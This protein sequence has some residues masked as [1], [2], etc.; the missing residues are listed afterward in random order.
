MMLKRKIAFLLAGV[1]LVS[2]I[3]VPAVTKA[4]ENK[5]VVVEAQKT[6]AHIWTGEYDTSWFTGD[7]ES[8]DIY[9]PEQF[10]GLYTLVNDRS[11]PLKN[12]T[13]NLKKDIYL[14]DISDFKNWEN[15]PPANSWQPIGFFDGVEYCEFQGILNGNGHKIVGMYAKTVY[16]LGFWGHGYEGKDTGGLFGGI[17]GATITDLVMDHCYVDP[18]GNGSAAIL[19]RKMAGGLINNCT[20]KNSKIV[21]HKGGTT[22]AFVATVFDRSQLDALLNFTVDFFM[23]P[24][25]V[26]IADYTEMLANDKLKGSRNKTLIVNCSV[27]NLEITGEVNGNASVAAVVGGGV[28]SDKALLIQ[29][30]NVTNFKTIYRSGIVIGQDISDIIKN[31]NLI[32]DGST[33]NN[34]KMINNDYTHGQK[35]GDK[36]Q[37]KNLGTDKN[38]VK[39]VTETSTEKIEVPRKATTEVSISKNIKFASV[40]SSNKEVFTIKKTGDNS[41]KITTKKKG[42]AWATFK[43]ENGNSLKMKVVAK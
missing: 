27:K 5:N 42:S 24:A 19:C 6:N 28:D 10:A 16:S 2:S 26:A 13:I 15:T 35:F 40:K 43:L 31:K 17:G 38:D 41:V 37:L 3:N 34:C 14:N 4:D 8:Y 20:I 1:M 18:Y 25:I 30:V 39:L 21:R 22:G 9:T 7:K 23:V 29:N 11:N 33:Y 32:I 12:I 36:K